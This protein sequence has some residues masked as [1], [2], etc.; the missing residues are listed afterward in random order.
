MNDE[1]EDA[2]VRRW[3]EI[4]RGRHRPL[5]SSLMGFGIEHGDGWYGLLDAL[6]SVLTAHAGG[7]DRQPVEAVQIKEKFG[8]LR[9]YIHSG[10]DYEYGAIALAE[11]LSAKICEH[12]GAPGGLCVQGG[13][14]ATLSPSVAAKKRFKPVDTKKA[15]DSSA[16]VPELLRKRWPKVIDCEPKLP[17]GWLGIAEALA[18][19]LTSDGRS[20]KRESARIVMLE[21]Y[22]GR[23]VVGLEVGVAEDRGAVAMAIAAADRTDMISGCSRLL[24]PPTDS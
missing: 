7:L 10:D 21:E 2:L 22:D 20:A 16:P 6:C 13:W 11:D 23:L 9:F 5:T 4:F 3:P 24:P 18:R 19:R 17:P 14:Y 15:K 12:T 8:E 1:Y